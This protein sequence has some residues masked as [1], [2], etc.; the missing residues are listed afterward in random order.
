[1]SVE[2]LP[3]DSKGGP[4]RKFSPQEWKGVARML[5][6]HCSLR[7]VTAAC[8][9]HPDTLKSACLRDH[10]KPWEEWA[11]EQSLAG[12]AKLK[13]VRYQLAIKNHAWRPIQWL[14]QQWLSES[15]KKKVEIDHT[16]RVVVTMPC[17]GRE[18]KFPDD[19]KAVLNGS[20]NEIDPEQELI[21]HD[22]H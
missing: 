12:E 21:S 13:V 7:E 20:C 5:E 22:T 1:M 2:P 3:R 4:K 17:N 10:G 18:L 16:E 14:S 8:H 15:D 6:A 9:T 11:E 19:S